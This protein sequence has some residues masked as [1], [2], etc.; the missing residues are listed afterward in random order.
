MGLDHVGSRA[1]RPTMPILRLDA[2]WVIPEDDLELK[3]VRSSGPGG[4]NVNKLSTKAE[5]RLKLQ[6]TTAL[7]PAQKRRL[8][9]AFPSRCTAEG[10]F[11]VTSERFRSQSMN[12][13]D[14]LERLA[15]MIRS[16]RVPPK[17]R[18]KTKPSRASKLKR[19]DTKR[20][21]GELKRQRR[22]GGGG[23]P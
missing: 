5:L 23:E 20:R 4:Q 17:A 16:V 11:I 12:Q 3:F 21:R 8:S 6:Q 7:Q 15:A 9:A 13:D 2:G 18:V 1:R 19:L 22:D 14:A 10:D